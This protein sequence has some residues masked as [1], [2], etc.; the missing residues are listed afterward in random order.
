MHLRREAAHQLSTELAGTYGQVV[1][2]DLDLAAMKQ[3][4]GRRAYRRAVADAAMGAIRPLLV[5]KTG[6]RNGILTVADRWFAS[7]QIHHRCTHPDGTPCRLVGKGRVDK[8]LV[9]PLTGEVVDRDH[10]AARNLRDW[11]DMPV[12]A[13]LGRRP[14]T[15]AV[16][17]VV[18]ETAAQTV[19]PIN[20]L[21]SSR[22]TTRTRV[23][24]NSE[25]NTGP[26]PA[27]KEP[28]KRSA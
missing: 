22:K 8:H 12:D 26:A 13:Q 6:R 7:S 20:G 24:V 11:P 15:S 4:M 28:R 21:R 19:D 9:C 2:E 1:I 16:P 25:G 23:A 14:R 5:Y 17:A 18:P 10:N 3:S 27:G